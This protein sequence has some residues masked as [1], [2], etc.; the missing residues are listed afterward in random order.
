M[1][2]SQNERPEFFQ[3]HNG[4]KAKL[5]FSTVEY[6]NRLR[7]L[8]TLMSNSG[9]EAA[10]L[11]SMHNI[12]YY[13]G[14]LY[15]AFG[16]PYAC[17]VTADRCVTIS[18]NIDG[19]QPWRRS[20][21]ENIIYTDW[22]RNNYWRAVQSVI[23]NAKSVGIEADHMTLVSRDVMTSMLG[24]IQLK[25]LNADIM[26]LR[27]IKSAEEIDLIKGGARTADIGGEAVKAAIKLGTREIDVAMAG[28][29]AMELEI[30]KSYPDSEIRDSWV[31]FQA[32]LNT[33]G[34]HNPVTT[35]KLEM[36]D[37]LSLNT[38]PMISGYYTAL[39][40]T[41]FLGEPDA[42]S[43]RVWQANVDA[44]ELGISLIKPGATC[45]GICSEIN[46]FFED[47][48]LLQ[49]RSFGYGHSFGVLSH[50]YGREAGLELREDIDTVLEP[51]MV[52]SM[53]PMLTL[54]LGTPGA[55]GYREHDILVIGEDNSVE[56]ITHFPYGPKHNIVGA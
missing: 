16:R 55:G 6:E 4:S 27:M 41:L 2:Q 14:F 49:Y 18:A 39:E 47:Q 43:L 1:S 53:E 37:I 35:A 5:P 38:F 56:N 20:F 28:R 32:G 33:D 7:K 44:H 51:G 52:I 42:D 24:N 3:L 21:G 29:D 23:P 12:A 15:C 45:S 22:K 48:N 36:G 9:V 17:V 25:D 46:R 40:R 31:W 13:S 11:T 8:R 50:Y 10:V 26:T 30:S 19:G 54:P 34:A